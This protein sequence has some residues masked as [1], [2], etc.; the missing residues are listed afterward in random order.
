MEAMMSLSHSGSIH[1][2]TKEAKFS[3]GFPSNISSSLIIWYAASF[4]IEFSGILNLQTI[5]KENLIRIIIHYKKTK[6][7]KSLLKVYF[8]WGWSIIQNKTWVHKK[9]VTG[10]RP[11][12]D[13][14]K[15]NCNIEITWGEKLGHNGKQRS[16]G[17]RHQTQKQFWREP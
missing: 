13:W 12:I 4:G 3:L 1:V 16:N 11:P 17:Q 10:D 9:F 15:E 2:V 8:S 6:E 5:K 7:K 14:K